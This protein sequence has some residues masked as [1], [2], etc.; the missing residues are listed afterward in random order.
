MPDRLEEVLDRELE[1]LRP[2]ERR[3]ADN[4]GNVAAQRAKRTIP[5][6][7]HADGGLEVVVGAAERK[8]SRR[9]LERRDAAHPSRIAPNGAA[10]TI[11]LRN[12]G[13]RELDLGRG[14]GV[15]GCAEVLAA[16][17]ARSYATRL[18]ATDEVR[19]D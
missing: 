2:V 4:V 10:D 13:D 3:L 11:G 12:D 15:H 5:D 9:R 1:D 14:T 19:Q 16:H 6:Q 17:Q 8:D 18:E 7:R